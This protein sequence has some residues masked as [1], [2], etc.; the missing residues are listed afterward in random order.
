MNIAE[1]KNKYGILVVR[2]AAVMLAAL[3]IAVSLPVDFAYA[4]G[5]SKK[6]K[7]KKAAPV[8][9]SEEPIREVHKVGVGNKKYCFFVTHNVV[10][11]PKEISSF[12]NNDEKL[13]NEVLKRAGLYMKESNCKNEKHQVIEPKAWRKSGG[14]LSLG[15]VEIYEEEKESSEDDPAEPVEPADTGDGSDPAEPVEPSDTGDGGDTTEPAD[16]G[17]GDN[18][19]DTPTGKTVK[20]DAVEALRMANPSDGDPVRLYMDVIVTTETPKKGSSK[21]PKKY[22]TFKKDSPNSPKLIYIAV[23]TEKDA[24]LG[25]SI[26]EEKK[27]KE[28]KQKNI[29]PGPD[30]GEGEEMLPEYRSISMTDRS[31]GPIEPTLKDGDPVTLEWIEPGRQT[32]SEG[33]QTGFFDHA[34]A[35][36]ALAAGALALAAALV[37]I[38][39]RRRKAEEDY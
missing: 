25:E 18:T 2:L 37:L 39:R 1:S 6:S 9:N 4:A 5:D 17:D 27:P 29:K 13:T 32:D 12:G 36:P 7:T 14:T 24:K 28:E 11:T 21:E 35:I 8:V 33:E 30:G 3:L 20:I 22:S 31:G 15:Q 26:C 10:M 16:T 23:A 19:A 34:W 38:L